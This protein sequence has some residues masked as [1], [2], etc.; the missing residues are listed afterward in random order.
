MADGISEKPWSD[1]TEADYSLEQWH[2]A[3]LIHQHQG[4]P[5]SKQQ[6]KLPVRTPAGVLSRAGVHAAAAALAGA[7]G[8]VNASADEKMKASAALVRLYGK[9]NEEPPPS[10][11]HDELA[12]VEN[13]LAHFGR[14]GM[15]WGQH[16]FSRGSESSSSSGKPTVPP[17]GHHTDISVDAQALVRTANKQEHERSDREIREAV[18]R[19]NQ[20]KQYNQLFGN[21]SE[22]EKKV[23]QLRLQKEY[24]DLNSELNP[25]KRSAVQKFVSNASKGFE[26]YQKIDGMMDGQ[27]S[28]GMARKL[29]LTKPPTEAEKLAASNHLLDLKTQ[30]LLKSSEYYQSKTLLDNVMASQGGRHL[31]GA[32][33]HQA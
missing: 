14:K 33:R 26:T 32:G 4:A 16:I 2:R 22:L 17:P 29:G 19:A 9:L 5:T 20:I 7:R 13:F 28:K 12:N 21:K 24:R 8:G 30:N 6:C 1:Y 27:L 25:P 23:E 3:C 18:N 11:A 31:P 10:L 15:K